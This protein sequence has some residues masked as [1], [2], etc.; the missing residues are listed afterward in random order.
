MIVTM[1]YA[2][3]VEIRAYVN[4]VIDSFRNEFARFR[5]SNEKFLEEYNKPMKRFTWRLSWIPVKYTPLRSP[6]SNAMMIQDQFMRHLSISNHPRYDEFIA[7]YL[8]KW[9]WMNVSDLFDD[10]IRTMNILN[11]KNVTLS[12]EEYKFIYPILLRYENFKRNAQ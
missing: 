10:M 5:D 8:D 7:Y 1:D 12:S 9:D 6:S 3:V 2:Q 11:L 4:D